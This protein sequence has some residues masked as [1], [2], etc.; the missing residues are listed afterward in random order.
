MTEEKIQ[1]ILSAQKAALV[2]IAMGTQN[3]AAVMKNFSEQEIE[4]VTI[5]I[6][7]LKNITAA[8]MQEAMDEFYE[9]IQANQYI[10]SGGLEYARQVLESAW[11]YK[12]AE[13]V[14]KHVEATTEVSAFFLLQTV[15]DK[16]LLNFLQN[17]H[18]QT[19]ALILAN[20]KPPQAA[21]ILSELPKESQSEVAYRLATMEKTSPELIRDIESTLRDQMGTV[22]GG[23]LSKAGGTAALAEILNSVNRTAEKNILEK[24][25]EIDAELSEE[26]DSLMF[27][28]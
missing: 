11:G 22:F 28:F 21:S 14:L 25:R 2:L 16:Q 5:E 7:K 15:D 8:T 18:P 13:E 6:A 10:V 17:E 9:M 27:L 19:V 24:L 20:L 23:N 26:V 4:K 1:E 3:A 12:R